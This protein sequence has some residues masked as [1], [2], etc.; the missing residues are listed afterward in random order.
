MTKNN[1]NL[2]ILNLREQGMKLKDI[3]CQFS[4]SR[5]RVRQIVFREQRKRS[6]L[7]TRI[8]DVKEDSTIEQIGLGIRS[9]NC[10]RNANIQT[11][12]DLT[13]IERVTDLL[14]SRNT[15]LKVVK[16]VYQAVSHLPSTSFLSNFARL[17]SSQFSAKKQALRKSTQ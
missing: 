5:E 12:R 8:K 16:E 7:K 15:G 13:S 3:A 11:V 6:F 4:I 14:R 17:N 10:L 2:V 9:Y 1:R